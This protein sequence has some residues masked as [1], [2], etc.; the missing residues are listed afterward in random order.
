[1]IANGM[2][3]QAL[4]RGQ[5]V[6][7]NWGNGWGGGGVLR[8]FVGSRARSSRVPRRRVTA[9]V[10]AGKRATLSSQGKR[11]DGTGRVL[12]SHWRCA[13]SWRRRR[14]RCSPREILLGR[15]CIEWKEMD[16]SGN[17]TPFLPMPSARRASA[18]F[19]TENVFE[20]WT[21][22]CTHNVAI[23]KES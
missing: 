18:A 16:Q 6:P 22:E 2:A 1:M 12:N 13:W 21:I 5:S 7:P 10:G 4:A 19:L 23:W 3:W 11:D 15:L 9:V 17:L 14:D 8:V 20:W